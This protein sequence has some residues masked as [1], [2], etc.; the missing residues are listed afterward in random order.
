MGGGLMLSKDDKFSG[1]LINWV[2]LGQYVLLVCAVNQFHTCLIE[3]TE[4]GCHTETHEKTH[5]DQGVDSCAPEQKPGLCWVLPNQVIKKAA[6]W[7][8]SY[9]TRNRTAVNGI[10]SIVSCGD[11]S[12][13]NLRFEISLPNK[14]IPSSLRGRAPPILF[15]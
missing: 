7:A 6:C 15:V 3:H 8:C 12:V 1:K 11:V 4:P 2:V 9:L 10:S 14:D 13:P 5:L